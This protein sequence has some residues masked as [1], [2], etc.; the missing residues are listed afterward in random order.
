MGSPFSE[1]FS[2]DNKFRFCFKF[3]TMVYICSEN[4]IPYAESVVKGFLKIFLASRATL[5]WGRSDFARGS[6][7]NF[8]RREA[9]RTVG[10]GSSWRPGFHRRGLLRTGRGGGFF[11]RR[12]RGAAAD[13]RV[14][15]LFCVGQWAFFLREALF[16]FLSRG[17]VG[18][19]YFP[20]LPFSFNQNRKN[21]Q[22]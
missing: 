1:G 8:F 19:Y 13:F 7:A 10:R 11:S 4:I 18:K 2:S 5:R 9:R 22:M 3:G 6:A 21:R 17:M 15:S 12:E 20:F 14:K 16:D